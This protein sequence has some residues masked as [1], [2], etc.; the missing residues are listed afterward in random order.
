MPGEMIVQSPGGEDQDARHWGGWLAVKRIWFRLPIFY[1]TLIGAGLLS[2]WL[3]AAILVLLTPLG[4][5]AGSAIYR[6]IARNR[7]RLPGSQCRLENP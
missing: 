2:L 6:W 1:V 7:H 5:P 3:A 4:N